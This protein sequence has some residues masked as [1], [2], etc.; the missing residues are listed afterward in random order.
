VR[1]IDQN[2]TLLDGRIDGDRL[3]IGGAEPLRAGVYTVA[4]QQPASETT[5]RKLL[6]GTKL[7][8]G[9][10]GRIE[11]TITKQRDERSPEKKPSWIEPR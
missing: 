2:G 4:G 5:G 6:P 10:N 11:R 9:Q 3:E 8:I 1:I 7:F